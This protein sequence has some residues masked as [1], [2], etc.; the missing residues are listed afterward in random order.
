VAE[1]LLQRGADKILK[2]IYAH[3]SLAPPAAG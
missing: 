1:E 2:A 3:S